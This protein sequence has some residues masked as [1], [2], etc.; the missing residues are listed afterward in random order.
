MRRHD[1]RRM[2]AVAKSKYCREEDAT[3]ALDALADSGARLAF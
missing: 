1:S 2:A 3:V